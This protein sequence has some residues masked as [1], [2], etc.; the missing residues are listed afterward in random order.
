ME[1]AITDLDWDSVPSPCYVVDTR[2][3]ERN[4]RVMAGLR[5]AVPRLKVLLALKGFAMWS[6]FAQLRPFVDGCCASGPMEAR[7]AREEMGKEVHAYAPAFSDRDL[8]ETLPHA[9]HLVFNSPAQVR[10]HIQSVR[11]CGRRV[12]IGLRLNPQYAEVDVD[13]YNPCAPCSRLGCT[14]DA[15][16]AD[17]GLIDLIDGLHL[18]VLCEQGADTLQRVVASLEERFGDYLSRVR[19]LNLGGG[20]WCSKPD[21]DQEL[22]ISVLRGLCE[23]YPNLEQL[24]LEPG[25]AWAVDSGVLVAQVE[26]VVHNGMPLAILDISVTAHMPDV[27]EMPYR[28]HIHGAADAGV[29]PHT[30]R[31]GGLTCLAGDVIGD[32][33]FGEA[34]R[35][36]QRLVFADMTHYTM[37]KTTMFNGV[38][39]PSIATWDGTQLR[40]VREFSY[41]DY[42]NR[43]S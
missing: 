7:L 25:E 33:S 18:H 29:L 5:A 21:Y 23:R 31:L 30:Y 3:L 4:A 32:W 37:V 17:P 6:T 43:L 1:T 2:L 16:D 40:V 10:R 35:V 22:L 19:W 39:H 26:D 20:H 27:L 41:E 28:P 9:D 11:D 36:G 38:R 12:E 13:L 8:T 34:L 42:R 14:R 15:L 24:Y